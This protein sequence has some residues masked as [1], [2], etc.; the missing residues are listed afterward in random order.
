MKVKIFCLVLVLAVFAVPAT[1]QAEILVNPGFE[2]TPD[3]YGWGGWGSGSG[4]GSA[5]YQWYSGMPSVVTDGTAYEGDKYVETHAMNASYSSWW[6]W[7]W[8]C[9]WQADRMPCTEGTEYT[10]S[11]YVRN[12]AGDGPIGDP[13]DPEEGPALLRIEFYDENGNEPDFDG[14]GDSTNDPDDRLTR[15][16]DIDNEWTLI[17]T[18][19]TCPFGWDVVEMQ[20]VLGT[21]WNA[22]YVDFDDVWFGLSGDSPYSG[23]PVPANGASVSHN[24]LTELRWRKPS[25][26]LP[27]GTVTCDIYLD[28]NSIRVKNLYS[29]SKLNEGGP[30]EPNSIAVTVEEGKDYYWRIVSFDDD[31]SKAL[32]ETVSPMW[33]FTTKNAA[34]VVNAGVNQFVWLPGG[35]GS[36]FANL[37]GTITDDGLP[38][39]PDSMSYTWAQ[40]SGPA[41][42][43]NS[44]PSGT[45]PGNGAVP[46]TIELDTVGAYV[47]TLS[48]DDEPTASNPP[49]LG[50][51]NSDTVSIYVYASDHTGL[52][53]HWPFETYPTRFND[54]AGGNHHGTGVGNPAYKGASSGHPKV[55]AGCIYFDGESYIDITD[56]GTTDP[57]LATWASP[58]DPNVMSVTCWIKTD[59]SASDEWAGI[60]HKGEDG[61]AD[62]TYDAWHL[63][64]NSSSDDV[65]FRP[66]GSNTQARMGEASSAAI[67]GV[68][69]GK[70]H[71]IAG[72]FTGDMIYLYVDGILAHSAEADFN[73]QHGIHNVWI[74][75]GYN[76][77]SPDTD[78]Y[79][80]GY[81]DEVRLYDVPLSAEKIVEQFIDDGGYNSCGGNYIKTDLSEDCYVTVEDFAIF[82]SWWLYCNDVT[83]PRCN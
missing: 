50:L 65:E 45:V 47:I 73:V 21:A 18:T 71:H 48:A 43:S 54:V 37:S 70:W 6:G 75:N 40:T 44:N 58:Y 20:V 3:L 83:D 24:T 57:N 35:G 82:A 10:L 67:K 32:V 72:V 79:F 36:A 42:V 53:A 80:E 7:G 34:P 76:E 49:G 63:R 55:G 38:D 30:Q 17:S 31:G 68:N 9:V 62:I 64:F 51:T 25:P 60:V 78:Y 61:D 14:D 33:W 12:G 26:I 19:E 28:P 11:A 59:G 8:S 23:D 41:I 69:D 13:E 77:G 1:T 16:Y 66:G 52:I 46:T 56:S 4:S 74:G 15:Y 29:I 39:P 2:D 27:G 22:V 81:M 5:G